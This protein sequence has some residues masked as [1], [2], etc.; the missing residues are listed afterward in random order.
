MG[1][2]FENEEKTEELHHSF[3]EIGNFGGNIKSS[4]YT[5]A[6]LLPYDNF[7]DELVLVAFSPS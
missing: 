3:Y 4:F 1:R 7:S 5:Y 6:T 2:E